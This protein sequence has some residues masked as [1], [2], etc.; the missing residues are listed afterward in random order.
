MLTALCY[1][2]LVMSIAA[3]NFNA[4]RWRQIFLSGKVNPEKYILLYATLTWEY[5]LKQN[6]VN[7]WTLQYKLLKRMARET[8]IGVKAQY[9]RMRGWAGVVKMST[10]RILA[11]GR[12]LIYFEFHYIRKPRLLINLGHSPQLGNY[13]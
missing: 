11:Q 12:N 13:G 6:V 10:Q 1:A 4:Q 5:L 8:G 9:C 2:T 3:I 7:S